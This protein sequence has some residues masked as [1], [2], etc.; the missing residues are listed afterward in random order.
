MSTLAQPT[1]GLEFLS[2]G[3]SSNG[4]FEQEARMQ[5]A[6]TATLVTRPNLEES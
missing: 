1:G 5:I 2:T 6:G 3:A 4:T